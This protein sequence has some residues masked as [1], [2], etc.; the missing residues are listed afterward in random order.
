[1]VPDADFEPRVLCQSRGN[2]DG[3]DY[4][5]DLTHFSSVSSIN[6]SNV[7]GN[8]LRLIRWGQNAWRFN[9]DAGEIVLVGG[10]FV[11]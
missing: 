2:F 6:I 1:M 9:T 7:A 3:R 8:P 4:A 10:N 5:F 11:H